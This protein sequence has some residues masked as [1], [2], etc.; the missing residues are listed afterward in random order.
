[1]NFLAH[2]YL[3]G[4]DEE[5]AVGNFIGDFVKGNQM[6]AYPSK[7]RKGILL[8]RAIDSY[9][10]SHPVV[11]ESKERLRPEYRHYAPVITDVFYD[12]FLANKW[13]FYSSENLEK[14]THAFYKMIDGYR[15][16]L[17]SSTR[18]MLGYM[19]RDNWLFNY[20]LLEGINRALTGM[21][22]RTKFD[23]KMETASDE[24][25]RNYSSYEGEFDRFFPDL[26]KH[27]DEFIRS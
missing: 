19:K 7:I 25:K 9:T 20:R 1:M 22:R 26:Q 18:H 10:D 17:P 2:I 4:D 16:Y 15:E 24:L 11:R 21:S 3:S 5:L 13:S 6:D 14:Y 27:C 8:H 23:S 12:H